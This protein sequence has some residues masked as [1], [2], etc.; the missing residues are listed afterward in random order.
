VKKFQQK[1]SDF[2]E[3]VQQ[4]MLWFEEVM[5]FILLSQAKKFHQREEYQ[6]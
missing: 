4:E 2:P 6:S 1:K 3:K 5:A